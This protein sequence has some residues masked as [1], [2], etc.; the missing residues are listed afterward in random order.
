MSRAFLIVMD[1]VGCGGAPDAADFGDAGANTLAHIARECAAGRADQGRQGPLRMPVL[2]G[3]GLS[4]AVHLASGAA[5]PG[6][7][8]VPQGRW[9]AATEVSRG[10]DTPSGH[11]E[12]AGQVVPWDWTYF[13]D[14]TPAFPDALV[15]EVCRHAGTDG[16]LGNCHAS[17]VPIIQDLGEAHLRSG[18]PICYTS[19]DSVFQ[20]AAH[21]GAFGLNRLLALCAAVAPTLHAMRVGRVIAR[22][23]TGT[24][25]AF[26]RTANRHDYAMAPPGP[27]ILDW[28]TAAGRDTHAVGKIGDIFSMQGVGRLWK[29]ASDLD[30]S[31]HLLTL[32]DHAAPGSLTFANFVE[33]DSLYGHR[34]DVAGYARALEWFDTVAGGFLARLGPGDLAIF[35]AD[36]GNDPT[37]R[38][39][40]HTRERV[41]VLCTGT[42]DLGLIGFTDV[43][44]MVAAHLEV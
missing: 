18:W 29:G 15:A 32:A 17:G 24:P 7:G 42:G 20:I 33:F 3:L 41:P 25:G 40:D 28:V 1:S 11:W 39:T 37:W 38:G 43:A 14:A 12:L 5:M 31:Q 9:G 34:R 16:I 30:L 8:A 13:P 44:A 2:D 36:H 19:A 21:E 26:A 4:A 10:K 23:F 6:M 27:T 35:T 22:P